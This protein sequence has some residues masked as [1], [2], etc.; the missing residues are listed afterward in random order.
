MGMIEEA[1][2]SANISDE[3]ECDPIV[4][5][6]EDGRLMIDRLIQSAGESHTGSEHEMHAFLAG[7]LNKMSLQERQKVFEELHGVCEQEKRVIIHQ[8]ETPEFVA[9]QIATL[10]EE[11][12][13]IHP[14]DAYKLAESINIDYVQDESFRLTFLRADLF[15]PV[16]AARRIVTFFE[17]RLALFGPELLTRSITLLD[18]DKDDLSTLK[19]GYFQILPSRD[20]AGR[21]VLINVQGMFKRAY[22]RSIN[23]VRRNKK[24]QLH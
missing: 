5:T 16:K 19:S 21:A 1:T 12:V 17:C 3:E 14:K 18:L 11:I 9:E 10:E 24:K 15:N 8:Q 13:N 6:D 23:M 4:L 2:T 20:T 7:E 22:K